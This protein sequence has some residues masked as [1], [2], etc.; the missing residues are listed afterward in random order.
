MWRVISVASLAT[1]YLATVRR[2]EWSAT[3]FAAAFAGTW[4]VLRLLHGAY[5]AVV[6]PHFVSPLRHL[7][8]PSGGSFLNGQ[9]AAI[10]KEPSGVPQLR[11]TRPPAPRSCVAYAR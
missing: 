4:A 8:E 9:Q 7:P 3:F 5:W 11:C 2:A 6:Y 1:A 10:R